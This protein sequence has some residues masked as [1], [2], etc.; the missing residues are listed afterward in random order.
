M[1]ECAKKA[2]L[3]NVDRA[4]GFYLTHLVKNEVTF[5]EDLYKHELD[6]EENGYLSIDEA[7]KLTTKK[8]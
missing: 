4:I 7:I 6:T 1:L 8:V 5:L 3:S 2:N